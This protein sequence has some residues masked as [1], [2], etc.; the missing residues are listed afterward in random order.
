MPIERDL[1]KI[2]ALPDEDFFRWRADAR[3]I[4]DEYRDAE[5]S[6]LY[7]ASVEELV[8]RAGQAWSAAHGQ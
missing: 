1:G 3:P 8:E 7:Q 6:A 4:L 2:L 5:L